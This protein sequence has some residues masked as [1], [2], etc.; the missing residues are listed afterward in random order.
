MRLLSM[1]RYDDLSTKRRAEIEEATYKKP[2][3]ARA[4]EGKLRGEAA[5]PASVHARP[6]SFVEVAR[7]PQVPHAAAWGACDEK[8]KGR[9]WAL[10]SVSSQGR[11]TVAR[12]AFAALRAGNFRGLPENPPIIIPTPSMKET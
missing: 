8:R 9:S 2:K 1:D 3:E 12:K 11:S 10:L 6:A 4:C 5:R 7:S